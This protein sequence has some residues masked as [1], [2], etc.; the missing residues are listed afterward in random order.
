MAFI[1]GSLADLIN[2]RRFALQ[3]EPPVEE[4]QQDEVLQRD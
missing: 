1:S 3:V 4:K 2:D